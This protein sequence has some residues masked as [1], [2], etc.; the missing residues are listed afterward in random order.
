MKQFHSPLWN[1]SPTKF[2]IFW[3][4]FA[5]T[6]IF[7]FN[8]TTI[9]NLDG[10]TLSDLFDNNSLVRVYLPGTE[11]GGSLKEV[12]PGLHQITG[13]WVEIGLRGNTRV[14]D[15]IFPDMNFPLQTNYP[16]SYQPYASNLGKI[17]FEL[18]EVKGIN[19]LGT[20]RIQN[21]DVWTC[22]NAARFDL[23]YAKEVSTASSHVGLSRTLANALGNLE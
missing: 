13:G 15:N 22:I 19:K 12:E 20:K 3:V 21:N 16:Q 11:A 4:G 10:G 6:F 1:N 14:I 18:N 23:G 2:Y 9:T 8:F 5:L 17:I 7:T